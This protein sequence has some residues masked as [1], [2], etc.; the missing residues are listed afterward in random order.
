MK[1]A[2]PKQLIVDFV[3]GLF[4]LLFLYT[5]IMKLKDFR[6]FIGSMSHTPL[7]RPYS[8]LLAGLIPGVEIAITILLIIPSTRFWGL[9]LA[10]GLMAIF[11]FYVAYILSTMKQL[12]CSCGG[13]IQEMNWREHLLFNISFFV[14]GISGILT[15]KRIIAINRSSRIPVK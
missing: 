8:T 5:A 2:L 7:L 9:L 14:A 6:F 4:V 11:T 12:P 13:V 1:W 10:T 15:Y 3:A